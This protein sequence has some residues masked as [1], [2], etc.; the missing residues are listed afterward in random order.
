[1]LTLYQF[2]SCP[3]CGK[4]RAFMNHTGI[5]YDT[6]EVAPFGMK[7]LD[8]TDHKKVPVLRDDDEIIVE[9]AAIVDYLNQDYGR[10][11]VSEGSGEWMTW[12]DKTLVQ[13]LPPLIHPNFSTSFKNFAVVMNREQIS[14]IK[15]FFVRLGGSVMMPKVAR[16]MKAKNNIVDVEQE[17]SAAIDRWVTEGL[18]GKAFFGG[19]QA[20]Q[21]DTSVFGVL[22]SS[23]GMGII[24]AQKS[25]NPA[26]AHWY[27]VCATTMA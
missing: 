5:E 18:A 12:V 4:V 9:S 16:K 2:Q 1:M 13:Y 24:E 23:R 10:L 11:S 21:V 7:E 15:G 17:F 14:G 22:H 26:F 19:E 8:F 3:F 20:D 6:V 25:R 27:D